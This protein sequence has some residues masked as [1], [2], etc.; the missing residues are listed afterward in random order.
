MDIDVDM[1]AVARAQGQACVQV[2]MVRDGKLLGQEYFILEGAADTSDAE[3]FSEF[4]KQFY[5]SR[6]GNF[7][8]GSALD[9]DARSPTLRPE[10]TDDDDDGGSPC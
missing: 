2:F 1:M 10:L 6:T 4:L 5:T 3:L 8:M 9:V 7:G